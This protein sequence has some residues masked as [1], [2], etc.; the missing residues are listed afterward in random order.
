[1]LT[2]ASIVATSSAVNYYT[3][4]VN[5]DPPGVAP[6]LLCYEIS[7]ACDKDHGTYMEGRIIHYTFTDYAWNYSFVKWQRDGVDYSNSSSFEYAV[8]SNH[9]FTAVFEKWRPTG[10]TISI[11]PKNPVAT[12][13]SVV[14]FNV[15]VT[16]SKSA[17]VSLNVSVPENW[18]RRVAP[19]DGEADPRFNST[20][21]VT[22][23]A[24]AKP[25]TY[26]VTVQAVSGMNE[27][28]ETCRVQIQ[29][30]TSTTTGQTVTLPSA[31]VTTSATSTYQYLSLFG[32]IAFLAGTIWLVRCIIRRRQGPQPQKSHSV[33]VSI[34]RTVPYFIGF[35]VLIIVAASALNT[36][37]SLDFI[38][39]IFSWLG[40]SVNLLSMPWTLIGPYV[41]GLLQKLEA[42]ASVTYSW[43]VNTT[44]FDPLDQLDRYLRNLGLVHSGESWNSPLV[45]QRLFTYILTY[46][47]SRYGAV[48]IVILLTIMILVPWLIR[49]II[50]SVWRRRK[51]HE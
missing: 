31:S 44:H 51:K 11:E 38:A 17:Y 22:V 46:F 1:M 48:G 30:S 37:A 39:G 28:L 14:S 45:L 49:S 36:F 9:T 8:D 6:G 2:C 19:S 35:S 24:E 20:V 15:I 33:V 23:P 4:T 41:L 43:G 34:A 47:T 26:N 3:I 5:S 29:A 16:T 32:L 21:T 25:G 7:R 27:H 40:I 18:T 50:G 13:G 12:S 10:I 42:A